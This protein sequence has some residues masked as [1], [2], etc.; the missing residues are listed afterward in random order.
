ME[1]KRKRDPVQ[2]SSNGTSNSTISRSGV[3]EASFPSKKFRNM[4]GYREETKTSNVL[5]RAIESLYA[6]IMSAE[7]ELEEGR[8]WNGDAFSDM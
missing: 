7:R 8:K 3:V 6:S 5:P 1:K 2:V 4:D